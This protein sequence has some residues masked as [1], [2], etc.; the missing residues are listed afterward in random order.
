MTVGPPSLPGFTLAMRSFLTLPEFLLSVRQE[1]GTFVRFR[2][3]GRSVYFV[4]EPALVEEVLVTK[5]GSFMK[6]RGTQRLAL[7]LGRGLLTSEP[8]EHLLHRRLMQPAFHRK[9]IE[10]YANIMVDETRKRV[11]G[12]RNGDTIDVEHE[13]NRLALE[14]V[15]KSVFGS[16]LSRDMDAIS[17]SLNSLMQAFPKLMMPFAELFDWMPTPNMMRLAH[18]KKVLDDVVYRM[19]REHRAGAGDPNDL[20]SMLLETQDESGAGLSD[21][22]IRDEAL[23]I[24][25]AGHETTAN[26]IAW[27]F[28]LLQRH[29]AVEARLA[30]HV[31]SVLGRRVATA[32]DVRDLDYVRAVFSEA[33]RLY[34]P[35]WITA[36]RATDAV[37]IGGWRLRPGDIAIV[38]PYVSHRDPRYFPDPERFDPDRWLGEPGLPR[39]AYYP[40]GGGRRLC[41]GEPFA[42]TE[43]IL[44]VATI[45]QLAYL[46][47]IGN[48]DVP[49]LPVVTLR[50]RLPIGARVVLRSREFALA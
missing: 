11:A 44:A 45:A 1:H 15:A 23:T 34:P 50:P 46:E 27:T 40:F 49:T 26:A 5:G 47:R 38:S 14:I 8:P 16:D 22:E 32:A 13:T 37:E 33:M 21:K 9:R 25:L 29:P 7:L 17:D 10:A 6:A 19:I 28:Y 24:L 41:I 4:S 18:G 48:D 20:L 39:F 43:G 3:P 36:R 31:D 12:W 35:A 2:N 42:W 30:G